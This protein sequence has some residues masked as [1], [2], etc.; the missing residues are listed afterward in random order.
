MI[1]TDLI[2]HISKLYVLIAAIS[3]MTAD[4]VGTKTISVSNDLESWHPF[5]SHQSVTLAPIRELFRRSEHVY[6]PSWISAEANHKL[7]ISDATHQLHALYMYN[8][9][10]DEVEQSIRVGNGPG[11][12]AMMGMKWLSRLND[13]DHLIYD[14]G[15]YRAYRYDSLLHNARSVSMNFRSVNAMSL[16]VISDSVVYMSP[17][18]QIDFLQTYHYDGLRDLRSGINTR[19]IADEYQELKPLRNFLLKNGH[20]IQY[21]NHIYYSFLFAPY[22]VKVGANGVVWIGGKEMGTGFPEDKKNS[23]QIKMPDVSSNPQQTI[24]IAAD[25]KSVYVLHNGNKVGFWKSLIA[26][27][28]NDFSDIDDLVNATDR[29]R[30]YDAATGRFRMEWQL[31]VRAR[32]ISVYGNYLY[33]VAQNAG[34]PEVIVYEMTR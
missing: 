28:T 33:V 10:S 12:L 8:L 16:H 20:S 15:S 23:N 6:E 11:E 1:M 30:V 9:L 7:L 18:N 5:E 34:T 4:G 21:G 25:D 29:L 3:M 14:V 17:M 27:V 24:S 26:T 2:I 19:I 22:I 31:P 32:L 13:G